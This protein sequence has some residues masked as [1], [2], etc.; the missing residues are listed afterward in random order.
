MDVVSELSLEVRYCETDQMGIVHHSNY[1]RYYEC[2]RIHLMDEIGFPYTRLE[3]E[4]IMTAV[5]GV[6]SHYHLPA[7]FGDTLKVVTKLTRV[8]LAKL[9]FYS[10]IYNQNGELINDGKVTLGFISAD[11]RRPVRC[12][13]DLLQIVE[14]LINATEK[15]D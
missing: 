4:G 9:V 11:T 15:T 2:G 13:E 10:E 14:P 1:I 6:E 8:P 7:K 5:V 3:S 12:P